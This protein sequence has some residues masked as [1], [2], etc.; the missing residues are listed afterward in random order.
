MF[1]TPILFIVF[2]RPN[3]AQQSFDQI[4]KVKPS[5]LFVAADGPR[6]DRPDDQQKCEATR[7]IIEQ[8]DWPC[9]L[10]TLFRSENRGCGHG[11]AEAITWFFENVERG[12]ILE[13]DC[14]ADESFFYFCEELLIKYQNDLRVSMIGGTNPVINWK[15]KKQSYLFTNMGFSWGWASWRRSWQEF[16]Y[17]SAT[18]STPETKQRI[19]TYLNHTPHFDHFASEFDYYFKEVRSDVWDFQWLL[20]RFNQQTCTILPTTNLITNIGFTEDST[21][22]FEANTN[23]SYLATKSVQFPLR[24][25]SFKIDL[26]FDRY[27]FERFI[28]SAPR[29]FFKKVVL[30]II[31]IYTHAK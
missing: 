1:S 26:F 10:K 16:D 6:P 23:I 8:I 27:V 28:S 25:T 29:S 3:I 4:R 31:K 17:L 5:F 7:K 30:K 20:T 18:W 9:E 14:M 19:R 11:P 15:E 12:V 13:D 2:N 24:H 22:T 21:H